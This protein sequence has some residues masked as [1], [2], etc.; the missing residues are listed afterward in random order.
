[1][2]PIG[3][4]GEPVRGAR[5]PEAAHVGHMGAVWSPLVQGRVGLA[6]R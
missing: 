3:G 5:H 1:M 2:G 6:L 4:G